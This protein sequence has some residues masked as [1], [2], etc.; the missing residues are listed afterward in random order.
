M[1]TDCD[2]IVPP[3][4]CHECKFLSVFILDL[5]PSF[6][7]ILGLWSL[8]SLPEIYSVSSRWFLAS[9]GPVP[10]WWLTRQPSASVTTGKVQYDFSK[11]SGVLHTEHLSPDGTAEVLRVSVAFRNIVLGGY[12]NREP[13]WQEGRGSSSD[14]FGHL[15]GRT[16][17][18]VFCCAMP[19][20]PH[21]GARIFFQLA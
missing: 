3:D 18:H 13:Y 8:C 9:C 10:V 4:G 15:F 19:C 1:P 14:L 16:P 6:S 2:L 17:R 11:L 21:W 20:A 7:S 12:L 5:E